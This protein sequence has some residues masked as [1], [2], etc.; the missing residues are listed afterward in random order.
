[1]SSF[2]EQART[3]LE[4]GQKSATMRYLFFEATPG[5]VE[6]ERLEEV[7]GEDLDAG[8]LPPWLEPAPPREEI[9]RVACEKFMGATRG[10]VLFL[11][12]GEPV[13]VH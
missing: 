12:N 2:F 6:L 7:I 9:L 3:M 5:V 1:M 11:R 4:L 13:N 10:H 8:V